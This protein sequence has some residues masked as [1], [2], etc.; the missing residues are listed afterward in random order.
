MDSRHNRIWVCWV[1]QVAH[2]WILRLCLPGVVIEGTNGSPQVICMLFLEFSS[3]FWFHPHSLPPLTMPQKD[4]KRLSGSS[5]PELGVQ[6]E[7]H[8]R[9]FHETQNSPWCPR[10]QPILVVGPPRCAITQDMV[11]HQNL[12]MNQNSPSPIPPSLTSLDNRVSSLCFGYNALV[13][14]YA[15]SQGEGGRSQMSD[16][17]LPRMANTLLHPKERVQCHSSDT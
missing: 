16:S 11:C 7:D 12:A 3:D 17:A 5:P 6:I 10:H 13:Q 2:V 4:M 8:G 1:S 9:I 14:S 15:D